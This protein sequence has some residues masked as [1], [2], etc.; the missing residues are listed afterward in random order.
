L[1]TF[2]FPVRLR[3]IAVL[4]VALTAVLVVP[5]AASA[6]PKGVVGVVG[7]VIDDAGT[8]EGEF[9]YTVGGVAV[10]QSTGDVYV[11]D[12]GN[13]R[14]QR[15][16]AD[17]AFVSQFGVSGSGEGEFTFNGEYAGI[18]LGPDGSVYVADTGNQR[19]QKFTADGTF[20]HTFGLG[21]D[22][23]GDPD[24]A[25]FEVCTAGSGCQFGNPG[26]GDG[27]FSSPIAVGVDPNDPDV[28]LVADRDN[29][30]IQRFDSSGAYL[31]Q[32]EVSSPHRVAVDSTGS[33]Y[34]L[35]LGSQVQRFDSAGAFPQVFAPDHIAS[36]LDIATAGDRVFVAQTAPQDPENPDGPSNPV[37]LEFDL[38][39]DPA[40]QLMDTHT[41]AVRSSS[42]F[43]LAAHASGRIYVNTVIDGATSSIHRVFILDD[44]GIP[45]AIVTLLPASDVDATSATLRAEIDSN[46]PLPTDYR[47]E[48]SSGGVDWTTVATGSVSGDTAETVSAQ[49]E[50]LRPNTLYRFR[51]V[52][53]KGFGNPD[54]ISPEL[55]FLTDVAAPEIL[56]SRAS[57]VDAASV[58]LVGSINPNSSATRYRFSYGIGAFTHA[59]PVPDALVGSGAD[60]VF[61]S[62]VLSDLRPGT[63]YQFRLIAS[64]PAGTTVGPTETFTTLAT[65]ASSDNR[66]YELVS[67]SDKVGGTGVGHWYGGPDAVGYVGIAAH[68]GERF[69][70][71]GQQGSVL[72]DG[73][74]TYANDWSFAER[75]VKGWTHR[76]GLS[77]RAFGVQAIADATISSAAEDL[78]LTGFT[79]AHVLRIFPEMENWPD[80]N[81]PVMRRW[82]EP[83]WELFGPLDLAQGIVGFG[84]G[85]KAV[86]ADGSAFAISSNAT[87]GLAGPGD[88]TSSVFG[89][90]EA[91]AG[92]VYLDEIT[93]P[94]SDTFPGDDGVRELVNVCT[95]GT[96][97]PVGDCPVEPI[98]DRKWTLTSSGGASLTVGTATEN[99]PASI[100]SADGSRL[101]FM[102]PDPAATTSTPP[103]P[104]V[105]PAQLFIRQRNTDGT[106][107]TRWISQTTVADQ[108]VSLRGPAF[109][110]GASRDGD[111][112]LFRTT[113]PLT[114][115]DPNNGVTD[116][117]P[118]S[119]SSDLY[120]YDLP[121]GPDA[122]PSTPDGDPAGGTLTRISAG[123]NGTGDCNSPLPT[124]PADAALR[125][126]SHDSSRVYF[127]CAAPLAG[128]PAPSNGTITAPG[129]N[130]T[131]Q[132]ELNLYLYDATN[133]AEPRWRF[134]AR[135]PT[136]GMTRCAATSAGRGSVLAAL[137]GGTG[138]GV[139][140]APSTNCVRG[141]SDGTL[142]TF[143]T[144]ARL[145]ADD[146]N[147]D[148]VDIYGYDATRDELTRISAP[149]RANSTDY[150]CVPGNDAGQRCWG[151]GGIGPG[152]MPL[153]MLGIAT[154]PDAAKTKLAFFQS[155]SQLVATDTDNAYDVYQWRNGEL[156][157]ISTGV[158][159]T[160]GAFYVGNDRTGQ[161]VYFATRDQ[162]T[163]QD[164]DRVLD[165][166]TARVGGGIPEPVAPTACVV[167]NGACRGPGGGAPAPASDET[168]RPGGGDVVAKRQTLSLAA[169][170]AKARRRA[171]RT[172]MLTVS[173]R[174]SEAGI[175]R[176]GARARLGGRSVK[177]A[178]ARKR[179]GGPGVVRVDLRLS[180]RARKVLRHGRALG[181]TL[182]ASQSG[183]RSR[184]ITVRLPGA[185][186]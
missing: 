142:V 66:G 68:D 158:S 156:S 139:A 71:R 51:V 84:E 9:S 41:V 176:L 69:A 147:T 35:Q 59:I 74:F 87:R 90:L 28:V 150:P 170:G 91:G 141:S 58:T 1:T 159:A 72:A 131:T 45:P 122:N 179:V 155:R 86:A 185:K 144:D 12:A 85:P 140:F 92:S 8:G 40:G 56:Q 50:G 81:V 114:G 47:F 123:P 38:A 178:G 33:I 6:A 5:A 25:T 83:G 77:K 88:P 24:V 162:L 157:L 80:T 29:N 117:Q 32:F 42:V 128:V 183:A 169:V 103:F 75:T 133:P 99:P 153:E 93:G 2:T 3:Y 161:S 27:E 126:A 19:V 132:D 10:N 63:T 171:A 53:N 54:V 30:R 94:F 109:F 14:V 11:V 18:A 174:V 7:A 95:L 154:R 21:V 49:A 167:L 44:G 52:T 163:W 130:Q 116:P 39:L 115:D 145:T 76:P 100:M 105:G 110:E 137:A 135:L 175:V 79:G 127:T 37:V 184:S 34:V 125:F 180:S 108:S 113:A 118:S 120:L 23:G 67:P 143:L 36:P 22:P 16:D 121:N 146:P 64:S 15:F 168:A 60:A 151:D 182:R 97:L 148:S 78:S 136:G 26:S 112:V 31:S 149:Q 177:V 124:D 134:I 43:G 119:E 48:I 129:G 166:Y 172:G 82:T 101:F 160:D 138:N 55:T 46:G 70:V 102:S 152:P 4:L 13:D 164:R 61:V 104:V 62:Q 17:G 107:T 89:D 181:V 65:P 186:P 173:V 106:V 98:G 111:K 57:A 96:V 73:A 165:V 20:V